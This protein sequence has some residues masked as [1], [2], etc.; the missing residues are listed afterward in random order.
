MILPSQLGFGMA[1]QFQSVGKVLAIGATY[2]AVSAGL[3][4]FNK[5]MMHEGRFPHAIALTALHMTVTFSLAMFVYI[6][7]PRLFPTMEKAKE[8]KLFLIKYIGPLGALFALALWSSN[9]AYLYSSVAFLQFMKEGNVAIV[10][11]M[12]CLVGLQQFN[13]NKFTVLGIVLCGCSLCIKGE[14]N[15]VMIGFILQFAS[16]FAECSKNIIGEIVMTGA[17]L[18]LDVLTFVIFQAPCSLVPLL[19]ALFFQ[20]DHQILVD[21]VAMWPLLLMNASLAFLLNLLIALTLKELSALAFV[22]IGVCKDMFIVMSSSLIFGDPISQQQRVGFSITIVGITLWGHLK[23][24]EQAE[25]AALAA[26]KQLE[27]DQI[28]LLP[29]DP[30]HRA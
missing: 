28:H 13:W 19:I 30:A 22:I 14:I 17:G 2:I 11:T 20:W 1:Q 26:G 6:L 9:A 12:S 7:A 21:F 3:I 29:K 10:F 23:I 18:K 5:F 25:K 15:F 27:E 16:Q 24:Q 8:N 4:T